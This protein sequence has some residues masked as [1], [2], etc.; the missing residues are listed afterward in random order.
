MIGHKGIG[1]LSVINIA[2][3]EVRV[4]TTQQGSN[5]R[6]EVSLD[7]TKVLELA[8]QDEDL[9]SHYVYELTK[10]TNEDKNSHYTYITLRNLTADMREL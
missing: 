1:A 7:I 6:M 10:W 9:E 3:R 8:R 2:V 5:E 4:L